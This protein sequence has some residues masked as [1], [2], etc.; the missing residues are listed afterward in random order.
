M[1]I[2]FQSGI[3][4]HNIQQNHSNKISFS[5]ITKPDI[6]EKNGELIK[7]SLFNP[8]TMRRLESKQ[9]IDLKKECK[10]IMK[11]PLAERNPLILDYNPSRTGSL[12]DK[13]KKSPIPVNILKS[14]CQHYENQI[15]YHFMSKDLKKEYGY[16]ELYTPIFD[17]K[18]E[19]L[20]DYPEYGIVGPRVIVSY[21]QNWDE[22]KVGGVGKLADKLAVKYC[23]EQGIE[24]NIVSYADAYSHV[25][26]FKRGKRFI[27]PKEGS[28][29]YIFLK[30]QYGKTDP[31]EILQSEIQNAKWNGTDVDL[32]GWGYLMMY[33]PKDLIEKYR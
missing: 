1:I 16:V 4:I 21:L 30:K 29:D 3:N 12:I 8:F 23:Q 31:N 28:E 17:S 11:D 18:N 33:L 22:S 25:A 9:K 27:P 26:H 13:K 10:I 5:G 20:K 6:F 7:L 2:N 32:L 24:P 14:E 15:A 19:L